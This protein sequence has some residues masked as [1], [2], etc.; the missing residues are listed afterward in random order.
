MEILI[1]ESDAQVRD[2][3]EEKI[4]EKCP[5]QNLYSFS[6]GKEAVRHASEHAL[7]A[8][9]IDL[10]LEDMSGRAVAEE[11]EKIYPGIV[12]IFLLHEN[13]NYEYEFNRFRGDYFL[14]IPAEDHE[15]IDVM[16]RIE[17]LSKRMEKRIKVRMFGA[18]DIFVDNERICFSNHK[19]M[20][21]LALCFDRRGG[22]VTMEEAIANLWEDKE[23]D[24]KVKA[25]YR[26]AVKDCRSLLRKYG[27]ESI[28]HKER[29]VTWV[30]ITK[31][32]CDF[33]DF[34]RKKKEA[35][36]AYGLSRSYLKECEWAS[37]SQHAIE[38]I[39]DSY[40]SKTKSGYLS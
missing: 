31:V 16:Q 15:L 35:M 36:D 20:E 22:A 19:A 12:I 30:D 38:N 29:A 2:Q 3:L 11:L 4:Q 32:D 23:Y 1:V 8:A 26:K 7:Q 18:F 28:F 40:Q 21:L 33:Y 5:K 6:W 37:D 34:L 27:I 39:Y 25:N 17:L 10:K 13:R 14:R 24:D 9:M